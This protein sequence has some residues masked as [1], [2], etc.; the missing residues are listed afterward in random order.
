LILGDRS[1]P[2]VLVL[3][4][5]KRAGF[6]PNWRQVVTEAQY[7]KH[8]GEEPDVILADY[9]LPQYDSLSALHLLHEHG[10]D[11]PFI[12]IGERIG[13]QVAVECIKEGAADY[14]LKDRLGRLGLAVRRAL[15]EKEQ[16]EERRRAVAVL[17]ENEA[18]LRGIA[19]STPDI[20]YLYRLA[21]PKGVEYVN[22]AV[23]TITG[24]EPAE[25][26]EDP[27][28]FLELIHPEDRDAIRR[29]IHTPE[30]IPSPFAVRIVRKDGS[31]A[32]LDHRHVSLRDDAR[33]LVAVEGIIRD[34]TK[35]RREPNGLNGTKEPGDNWVESVGD[36]VIVRNGEGNLTF[37]SRGAAALLGF[38]PEDLLALS[39][40]DIVAS[41]RQGEATNT[42]DRFA[43]SDAGSYELE[44]CRKDGS[45]VP[46]LVSDSHRIEDSD[47][48]GVVTVL[49]DI[50]D[51][52]RA[53]EAQ[54]FERDA[55]CE[56]ANAAV[57][58]TDPADLCRRILAGFVRVLEFDI[59]T[60]LVLDEERGLLRPNVVVGI[61]G[62]EEGGN[63]RTRP[64]NDLGDL[65]VV[66]AS[67]RQGVLTED[68]KRQGALDPQTARLSELGIRSN[69]TWPVFGADY[70]LLGV[71]ELSADAPK[72]FAEEDRRFFD[73]L[74]TMLGVA[75][76][77]LMLEDMTARSIEE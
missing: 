43:G 30:A 54:G 34:V 25:F 62:K 39:W 26:Y 48:V 74:A 38:S 19:E 10:L 33:N 18:R 46:V 35:D 5:L 75:L 41:A 52:R 1:I 71:M 53:E 23:L 42:S 13:E 17:R 65:A 15:R 6:R 72:E 55:F 8:L 7:A 32:W 36:G 69:V 12:I 76:A 57:H 47:S 11:I 49:I 3:K 59:G 40:T 16:R 37:V 68:V 44:L 9:V 58:A 20:I 4:E 27:D 77:R 45:R 61:H 21:P 66:V 31:V 29:R 50:T 28:L 60:L 2:V 70:K 64:M 51:R 56:V 22:S 73:T 67:T 24:Y 63:L 14:L